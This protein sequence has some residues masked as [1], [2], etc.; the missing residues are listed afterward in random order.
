MRVQSLLETG[1]V[2]VRSQ[3]GDA[4]AATQQRHESGGVPD[5]DMPDVIGGGD[6]HRDDLVAAVR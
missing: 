6:V 1:L 5:V 3:V 4:R 2:G